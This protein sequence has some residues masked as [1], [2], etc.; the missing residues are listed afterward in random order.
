[1]VEAPAKDASDLRERVRIA[2]VLL[3]L[4]LVYLGDDVVHR[5]VSRTRKRLG[6]RK[7]PCAEDNDDRCASDVH[8]VIV[9]P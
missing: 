4:L 5:A 8:A 3:G 2:V 6:L 9:A 1:M 7:H